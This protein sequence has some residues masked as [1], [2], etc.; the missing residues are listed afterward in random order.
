MTGT[1]FSI[2]ANRVLEPAVGLGAVELSPVE[3]DP[4]EMTPVSPHTPP[5]LP[6]V[7]D[8]PHGNSSNSNIRVYVC[9]VMQLHSY[10]DSDIYPHL[11][12]LNLNT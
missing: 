11:L 4:P 1:I 2:Q 3:V 6:A 7:E 10:S 9:T 8:P 12:V 5:L